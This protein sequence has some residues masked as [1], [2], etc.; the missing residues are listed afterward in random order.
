MHATRQELQEWFDNLSDDDIDYAFELLQ[1]ANL[2]LDMRKLEMDDDVE[3]YT[4][5]NAVL[6]KIMEMK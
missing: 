1:R 4:E 2:E 6:S 3:D 5:A